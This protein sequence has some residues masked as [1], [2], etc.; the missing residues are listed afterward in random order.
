MGRLQTYR[1]LEEYVERTEADKSR[2]QEELRRVERQMEEEKLK[3][4]KGQVMAVEAVKRRTGLKG[5]VC[6]EETR[7]VLVCYRANMAQVLQC[8]GAVREF[9]QCAD[10]AKEA[11]LRAK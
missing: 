2:M 3:G 7:R 8:E 10:R 11:M 9:A 5:G 4:L 1:E 6:E